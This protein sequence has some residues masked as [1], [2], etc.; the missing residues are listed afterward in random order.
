MTGYRPIA[1][2]SAFAK[3]FES[4]LHKCIYSQVNARLTDAQHGFRPGR[5]TGSNL[6]SF[7]SHLMPAVDAGGQVDSAYF[8]FQ[9]AFDSVDNDILLSKFSA[10]GFTP[11]LL[12]FFASYLGDRKQYVEYAGYKS[13]SYYTFSGVSQGSNL[14]PLEFIIMVNDLPEVVKEAKCLLFADDLKVFLTVADT[15]DCDRLQRDIDRVVLWSEHNKLR[16]NVAKCCMVSYTRARA[17]L[18]HLYEVGGEVLPLATRVRDLGLEMV[19][20][21]TF[22][23]HIINLCAKSF[24]N[25]G[26]ILRQSTNFNNTFVIKILYNA[27]VRSHLETNAL[28]WNPHEAKYRLMIEKIQNKFTR[29]LYLKEYG[30]Y[31][32]YP[33]MYPSLF[34]MG[35]VGYC[36]L[37]VRRDMALVKYIVRVLSGLVHHE[38]VLAALRLRAPD[39]CASARRRPALLCQPIFRTNLLKF[40]PMSHAIRLVN[41]LSENNVD[42]FHHSLPKLMEIAQLVLEK[43]E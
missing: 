28:I 24:R 12:K 27:L 33:L 25:M 20:D 18:R 30:V 29:F 38:E 39:G 4:V 43:V 7:V 10:I 21:L 40:A 3:V 13:S 6:L 36:R 42:I 23:K 5:S 35:M 17:P 34:V 11:H 22:R 26:F 2:L 31:P 8:D 37:S 16:F 14:G 41:V 19:P 9:K 15:S 32:Y 1:V